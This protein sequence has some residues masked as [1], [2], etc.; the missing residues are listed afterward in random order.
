MRVKIEQQ[1]GSSGMVKT[2]TMPSGDILYG[3]GSR[4]L[5]SDWFTTEREALEHMSSL[6]SLRINRYKVNVQG[7]KDAVS[8]RWGILDAIAALDDVIS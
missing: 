4:D 5:W 8:H 6:A 3:G 2:M 1:G 7:R